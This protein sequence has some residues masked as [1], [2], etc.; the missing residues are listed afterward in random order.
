[1]TKYILEDGKEVYVNDNMI[2]IK[3]E[4]N[5]TNTLIMANGSKLT[6]KK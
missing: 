6:V 4:G 1:M 2:C 3:I 5:K